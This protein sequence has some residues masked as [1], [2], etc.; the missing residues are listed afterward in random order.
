MIPGCSKIESLL[1]SGRFGDV[2]LA[3]DASPQPCSLEDRL[4]VA[5]ALA[6]KGDSEAA[7]SLVQDILR[8]READSLRAHCE[9]ILGLVARD[10]GLVQKALQHLQ[11]SSRLARDRGQLAQEA[12]SLLAVFRILSEREHPQVVASL[13]SEVRSLAI[14]AGEPH[15]TVFLHESVARQEAQIGNLDEARRHL[16]IAGSL[17]RLHPNSWLEQLCEI[18]A[19]CVEFSS[20]D[21]PL[22]QQHLDKAGALVTDSGLLADT[23]LN[24]LGHLYLQM[25]QLE[26]AEHSLREIAT[27]SIFDARASALDGLARVYLASGRL[28]E[29]QLVLDA[30]E[31]LPKERSFAPSFPARASRLTKIRLL[32]G[33]ERWHEATLT[34]DEAITEATSLGDRHSLATALFLKARALA[35]DNKQTDSSR[36]LCA[37]SC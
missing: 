21:I 36:S 26:E 31:Q 37:A 32:L 9:M 27:S 25:G 5:E 23:V 33:Q 7:R 4:S 35:G 29:C 24:N 3:R 8:S 1:R 12:R 15:L 17:L 10:L 28:T 2:I 16:R 14:R 34:A 18:N 30:L 11:H 20:C 22:A 13:L 6:R 19:F